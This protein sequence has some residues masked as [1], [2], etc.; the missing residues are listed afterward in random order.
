MPAL[1]LRA[2]PADEAAGGFPTLQHGIDSAGDQRFAELQMLH[3][4]E[5]MIHVDQ[6]FAECT[7]CM[8]MARIVR[9]LDVGPL[10]SAK[11]DM[12]KA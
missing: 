2:Q 10:M 1:G 8:A 9:R 11:K 5:P 12:G 4:F 3:A 6:T 7:A